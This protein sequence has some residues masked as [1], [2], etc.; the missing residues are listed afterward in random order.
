MKNLTNFHLIRVKHAS[1]SNGD[2]WVSIYSER[3]KKSK[4]IAYTNESGSGLPALDSAKLWL[5][6]Q[7]FDL[8]GQSETTNHYYIIS[9][10][11]KSI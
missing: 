3:F 8:I 11:F 4:R 9:S 2:I 5:E 1:N 10:T 6:S 7:G